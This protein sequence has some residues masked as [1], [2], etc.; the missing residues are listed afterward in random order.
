MP[1]PSWPVVALLVVAL[2]STTGW[3]VSALRKPKPAPAAAVPGAVAP[4][5]HGGTANKTPPVA[6]TNGVVQIAVPQLP[7][8]AVNFIWKPEHVV[9]APGQRVTF[10]VANG[11]YM[12][13]N[14]TFKPAKVAQNLPV[15]AT[16]TI[17]FTA[18]AKPGAYWFYCKYHL[19][20]MEGAVT[21]R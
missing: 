8:N 15:K 1:R 4:H 5:Q 7:T 19:N 16:T 21:V 6:P 3:A 14:F 10:K 20:M 12:Q 18:P 11:D 13:H 2:V 9:L 17:R